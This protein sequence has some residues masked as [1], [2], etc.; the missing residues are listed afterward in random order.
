MIMDMHGNTADFAR[1]KEELAGKV[2]AKLDTL[3]ERHLGR[4]PHEGEVE[5]KGVQMVHPNGNVT[6][7]WDDEPLLKLVFGRGKVTMEELV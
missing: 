6:F 7:T 4:K 2:S 1:H 5:A 3:I